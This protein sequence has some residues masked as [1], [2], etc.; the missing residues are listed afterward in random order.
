MLH[1]VRVNPRRRRRS[2]SRRRRTRRNPGFGG[3]LFAMP[4]I[5]S[6]KDVVK[7]GAAGLVGWIGVN[8]ALALADKVGLAAFKADKSP[9]VGALINAA[10]RIVA[11]PVIAKLASRF[12]KLPASA[13]MVGG[14]IN[15]VLHGV[16]DLV[17]ANPNVVP[18]QVKPL[19]LGYDGFGD[20]ATVNSVGRAGGVSGFVTTRNLANSGMRGLGDMVDGR[21]FG[22]VMN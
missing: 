15:V 21:V 18:D 6:A 22:R 19:L 2:Y 1:G 7:V 4:S 12:L 5:R 9:T 14:G 20:F 8:A 11:T 3:G 16:Q 10:V 17:A 13:V